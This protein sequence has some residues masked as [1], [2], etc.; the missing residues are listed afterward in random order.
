MKHKDVLAMT[1]CNEL[2]LFHHLRYLLYIPSNI[3]FLQSKLTD[4]KTL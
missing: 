1:A 3:D 4:I 2:L